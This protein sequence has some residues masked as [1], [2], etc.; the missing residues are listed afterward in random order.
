[1]SAAGDM[2]LGYREWARTTR[3]TDRGS[4]SFTGQIMKIRQNQARATESLSGSIMPYVL[5]PASSLEGEVGGR[6]DVSQ[7]QSE[8]P[9]FIRIQL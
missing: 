1:M 9:I 3:T 7:A 6:G 4:M 2:R 8:D 5:L